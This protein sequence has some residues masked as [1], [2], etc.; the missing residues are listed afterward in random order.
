MAKNLTIDDLAQITEER[1]QGVEKEV[2]AVQLILREHS[3]VLNQHTGLLNQHHGLLK[4]MFDYV[5]TMDG[6]MDDLK[7]STANTHD[8]IN[9]DVRL[10]AVERKLQMEG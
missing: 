8:I 9:I 1:I 2:K 7:K 3:G 5:K 6:K 10:E 4:E